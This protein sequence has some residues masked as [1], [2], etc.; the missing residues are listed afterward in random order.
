MI[1]LRQDSAKIDAVGLHGER[2]DSLEIPSARIK[3]RS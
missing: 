3:I 2:I 1:E